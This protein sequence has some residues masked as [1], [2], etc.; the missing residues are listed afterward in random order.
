MPI[1]ITLLAIGLLLVM[2]KPTRFAGLLILTLL[3]LVYSK[4]FFAVLAVGVVVYFFLFHK[5]I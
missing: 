4:L 5:S 1:P 3:A 2:T